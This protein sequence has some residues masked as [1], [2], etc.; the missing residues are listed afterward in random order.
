MTD[1]LLWVALALALGER[2]AT[3][4]NLVAAFDDIGSIF[5]ASWRDLCQ[6][7]GVTRELASAIRRA[8]E[9]AE[10]QKEREIIARLGLKIVPLNSPDYPENLRHI[11]D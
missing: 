2:R 6:V 4:R 9:S 5:N 11:P 1:E 10:L 8:P 3:F 7:R